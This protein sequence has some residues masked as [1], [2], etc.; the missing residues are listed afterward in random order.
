MTI[1][2]IPNGSPMWTSPITA[3]Y[4]FHEGDA[5]RSFHISRNDI[6]RAFDYAEQKLKHLRSSSNDDR[7]EYYLDVDED[8]FSVS[9]VADGGVDRKVLGYVTLN[10]EGAIESYTIDASAVVNE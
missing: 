5:T 1:N 6:K 8:G 9:K 2:T 4:S 7:L 10:H 3:P